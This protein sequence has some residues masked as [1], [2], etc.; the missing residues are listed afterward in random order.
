MNQDSVTEGNPPAIRAGVLST[1]FAPS[2]LIAKWAQVLATYPAKPGMSARERRA[3]RVISREV[4]R[5]QALEN[6]GATALQTAYDDLVISREVARLT[7]DTRTR[8]ILADA[9]A[10][11]SL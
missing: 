10:D 3:H 6:P 11:E 9:L 8:L 4:A 1:D 5:L 2:L 7:R